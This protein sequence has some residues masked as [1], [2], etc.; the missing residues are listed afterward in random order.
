MLRRAQFAEG[1]QDKGGHDL[2]EM[3]GEAMSRACTDLLTWAVSSAPSGWGRGAAVLVS[4]P[5]HFLAPPPPSTLSQG[6][7]ASQP[8]A[9]VPED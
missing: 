1:K 6:G 9:A 7:K 2:G 4:S 3:H 5:M 8:G